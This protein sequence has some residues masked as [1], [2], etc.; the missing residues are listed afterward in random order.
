MA[1]D[2]S[3]AP[4]ERVNITYASTDGDQPE[5]VELPLRILVMGNF[6]GAPDD[7]PL[8][9]R[10]PISIDRDNFNEVLAEQGL[11]LRILVEDRLTDDGTELEVDLRFDHIKDFTPEGIAAQ[12]PELQRLIRLR[13]ALTALRGPLGNIP[14]FRK[15]IEAMLADEGARRR[16][17]SEVERGGDKG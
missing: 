10:K 2:R 16:L 12:V 3:V 15:K 6:T 14:R 13:S 4:K 17:S 8:E 9:E 11:C 7:R 5:E 1:N